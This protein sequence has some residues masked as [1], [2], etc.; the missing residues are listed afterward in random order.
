[1]L[2][3]YGLRFERLQAVWQCCSSKDEFV[4]ANWAPDFTAQQQALRAHLKN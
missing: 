1:V 4:M 2:V 3:V